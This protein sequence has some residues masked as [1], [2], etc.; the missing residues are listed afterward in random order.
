MNIKKIGK[1]YDDWEFKKENIDD[2]VQILTSQVEDGILDLAGY[3]KKIQEQYKW[4][5]KLLT[6]VEKDPNIT[7]SQ[8]EILID[9]VNKRKKLIE[10]ELTQNPEE[11]G[12]DEEE[13]KEVEKPAPK[14]VEKVK[15]KVELMTQK[16]L[17]PLF[18]VPK[19]KEQEE[20]KRLTDVVTERLAE[21]R[22]ALDYFKI[23]DFPEQKN[24]AIARAKK[25]CIEL[26][27]FKMEN[28]K[29]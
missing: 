21:Y 13:P 14:E 6:F 17:S 15:P 18:D 25:I 20:I 28:G 16:S 5:S 29:K 26:K 3:K 8:K 22:N 10:E 23:N 1:D 24:E 11:A 12:E 2:R 7:K 9:R 4:E 27:K 19:D